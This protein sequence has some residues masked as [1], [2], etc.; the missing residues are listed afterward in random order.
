MPDP[1]LSLQENIEVPAEGGAFSITYS[2]K[3]GDGSSTV[4]ASSESY[5]WIH[6]FDCSVPEKISF[7]VDEYTDE[8]QPREAVVNVTY[9]DIT[10]QFTVTQTASEP[11]F[12]IE[13]KDIDYSTFAVNVIPRDKEM[14]YTALVTEKEFYSQFN[15]DEEVIEYVKWAWQEEA[16]GNNIP[17]ETYLDTMLETGD[18][19]DMTVS[20]R[21]PG[22]G[23]VVF[24]F[25]INY[26]LEAL[27][28]VYT[29]E[30]T[31]KAV[32]LLDISYELTPDVNGADAVIN[33]VP[34]DLEQSYYA[35]VVEKTQL[36]EAGSVEYWQEYFIDQIKLNQLL[37]GMSAEETMSPSIHTGEQDISLS[38]E[39]EYAAVAMAASLQGIVFS[40]V[41]T[42]EFKTNKANLS[43]N[44]ISI[45]VKVLDSHT[46]WFKIS[47]TNSDP[48]TWGCQPSS[49]YEGMSDEEMLEY[50]LQDPFIGFNTRSGD[51][52]SNVGATPGNTYT[53]Y[54]FGYANG[55]ATTDLKRVE[56]TMPEE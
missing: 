38:P 12:T 11:Y 51:V 46:Y 1:E 14:T 47:T 37:Y 8:T 26:D 50:L 13:V 21:L 17:I 20:N 36:S 4:E 42:A 56:F 15:T 39:T 24:V 9:G 2:I 16:E 44:K 45:D 23:Y 29:S 35:G 27:T 31:T 6:T 18:L 48:Y 54:A 33:I 55:T 22:T 52:E 40:A 7:T 41:S 28:G 5:E 53:I 43:D 32:E 34:S 25:G 49:T 30:V 19:T 10:E 3:N